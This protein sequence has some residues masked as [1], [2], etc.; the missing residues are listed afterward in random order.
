MGLFDGYNGKAASALC[1]EHLHEAV[2]LEMS[3][4]NSELTSTEVEEAL[5][6]RLYARMID[7]NNDNSHIK[8]IGDV[9]RCAYSK[10][11][12]L[13]SRGMHETSSVRWS[14]TSAFTAVIVANDKI[15]DLLVDTEDK[16][17]EK[18]S[19]VLG[20]MHVANCGKIEL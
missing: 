20:Q 5:I 11:D 2:L 14:G 7:P 9:Y 18:A 3:K 13:L 12:Y 6:N 15:D 10:M 16:Q 8:S 1:R 4:L 19:I 17:E